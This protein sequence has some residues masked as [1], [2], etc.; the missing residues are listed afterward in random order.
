MKISFNNLMGMLKFVSWVCVSK[1]LKGWF[2][3]CLELFSL[4]K[5]KYLK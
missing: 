1:R 2:Y 3:F 5:H 4:A